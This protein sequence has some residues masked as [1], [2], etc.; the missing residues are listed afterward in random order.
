MKKKAILAL[1]D[2]LTFEGKA[3]GASGEAMG[4]LVFNTCM[5]GYQEVITDPSYKGQVVTMTYPL[6]GNYGVNDDDVESTKP[7]VEAFVVKE[8]SPVVSNFRATTSLHQY[9]EKYGIPGIEGI[10]TRMITKHLRDF[11]A[12]KCI[13][14]SVDLD[15]KSLVKKAKE[16]PDLEGRDLV[17]EVTVKKAYEFNG[18]LMEDFTWPEKTKPKKKQYLVACLDSG[19][20]WNILRK[21]NQH[22]FKL[23]V[24]PAYA[25]AKEI[26]ADKLDGL[27]LS[28]GP[29]DPAP[30]TYLVD[31]VKELIGKVPI[32]GICLGHQ[33]LGQALGGKT[34]K[35]KFGHHGGNQPVK[36]LATG[37]IEITSQN[38]GFCVDLETLDKSEVELTHMNLNDKTL[39]GLRYKKYPLFSVQYHPEAS[40]GPHDSDYLFERFYDLIAS[41]G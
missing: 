2:G 30:L 39:E 14:S 16:A 29:G 21:L 35:L 26:M 12:K 36:D 6:I 34:Y 24:Y 41:S 3:F 22:G 7:Q 38:H 19:I 5:M 15:P 31:T 20:K 1:E 17:K 27:F 40:P 37:K 9:L 8:L 11:G 13:V 10:D 4:E 23:K 25:N 28:N 33:I 18:E 32:F